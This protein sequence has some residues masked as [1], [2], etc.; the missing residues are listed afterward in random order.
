MVERGIAISYETIRRW[1]RNFGQSFANCLRHRRPGD[2]WQ[3]VHSDSRR[4]A[5]SLARR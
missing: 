2:K 1:Y 5:L 3:G 4:A